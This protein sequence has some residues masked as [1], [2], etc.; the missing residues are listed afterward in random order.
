MR[1]LMA[2]TAFA[3]FLA[4]PVWAQRGGG[5]HGGFGGGHAGGFGGHA[6]G[7]GGHA[8]FSGGHIGGGIS[9]NEVLNGLVT[10]DRAAMVA[11]RRTRVPPSAAPPETPSTNGSASG[12]R[13]SA[14]RA[15]P[16]EAI[17]R[18]GCDPPP[19]SLAA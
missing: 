6:G 13:S 5:G 3:L 10:G 12:F 8:G 11:A 1:R 14:C 7:F 15:V 19:D 2:I 18:T 9:S 4:V 16:A 17:S